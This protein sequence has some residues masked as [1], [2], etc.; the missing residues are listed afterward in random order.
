MGKAPVAEQYL[1]QWRISGQR[2]GTSVSGHLHGRQLLPSVVGEFLCHL[3]IGGCH[4][5]EG[6]APQNLAYKYRLRRLHRCTLLCGSPAPPVL[7]GQVFPV[8][9]SLLPF[10]S[11]AVAERWV[12]MVRWV[13]LVGSWIKLS[14]PSVPKKKPQTCLGHLPWSGAG[15]SVPLLQKHESLLS[16]ISC[17]AFVSLP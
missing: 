8:F 7:P 3:C 1:C 12:E 14:V 11:S 6:G 10:P 9:Q 13:S 5:K 4:L 2:R 15:R 16:P 17:S